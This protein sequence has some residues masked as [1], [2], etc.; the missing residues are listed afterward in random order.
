MTGALLD[1]RDLRVDFSRGR[2]LVRAVDGVSLSVAPGETVGLVGESG[3]GKSTIARA[4]TGLTPVS[5]GSIRFDGA[6]VTRAGRRARRRL[7]AAL[8]MVFQDPY[9]S[10]NPARTIGDTLAEPL[11]ARRE[12]RRSGRRELVAAALERVGLPAD[13][14]RRYPAEFSGGQRQ[15]IVIAR[16]LVNL[17]RLVICDE[18]VSGLDTSVQAQIIN[19][20]LDLRADLGLGYLFIT[21]DLAVVRHLSHRVVVLYRGQVMEAGRTATVVSRPAHPYTRALIAAA[22]VPDP[23]HRP[24]LVPPAGPAPVLSATPG[25][26]DRPGCRFASRCP[27]VAPV[28][29]ARRPPLRE[30]ATG[31]LVSCVRQHELSEVHLSTGTH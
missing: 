11:L 1:I 7:S 24:P 30:S 31:S 29:L 27:Y 10:L 25:A 9:S 8:Q 23:G 21:H 22:P 26:A 16:A 12:V 17:P 3:S 18:P 13:A 20:L 15:R 4:V 19:L 6:D 5:G 28:C 14:A 2:R